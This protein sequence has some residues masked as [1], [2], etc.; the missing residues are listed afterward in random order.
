MNFF[1]IYCLTFE[2]INMANKQVGHLKK[3]VSARLSPLIDAHLVT[4]E[5]T[6]HEGNTSGFTYSIPL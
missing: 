2:Q 6:I 4:V 3:E 5:G 1:R